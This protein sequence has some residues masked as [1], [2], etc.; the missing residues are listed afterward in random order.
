M[1]V[2]RAFPFPIPVMNGPT[3]PNIGTKDAPPAG[4]TGTKR[5]CMGAGEGL[6]AEWERVARMLRKREKISERSER[7]RN[8]RETYF[9]AAAPASDPALMAVGPP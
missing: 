7:T 6:S 4:P 8:D 2:R 1:G 3:T 9:A 5:A